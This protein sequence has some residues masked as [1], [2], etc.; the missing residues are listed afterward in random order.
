MISEGIFDVNVKRQEQDPRRFDVTPLTI[1][2][3]SDPEMIRFLHQRGGNLDAGARLHGTPLHQA[4]FYGKLESVRVLLQLGAN[5]N[6]ENE[7]GRTPLQIVKGK[8][9]IETI[10][11][12]RYAAIA[13]LLEDAGGKEKGIRCKNPRPKQ[14]RKVDLREDRSRVERLIRKA[15]RRYVKEH[16]GEPISAVAL[17]ACAILG[18][19]SIC[20]ETGEFN[21]DVPSM[22]HFEFERREFPKWEAAY[23]SEQSVEVVTHTG[24][25]VKVNP[26]GENER[27]QL[28]FYRFLKRVLR[29]LVADGALTRLPRQ[30]DCQV[31]IE[32]VDGTHGGYWRLR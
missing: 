9:P 5:P 16:S 15:V 4:A 22:T 11:R 27:Y 13:C 19:V 6:Y 3:T 29:D 2:A 30:R 14:P 18:S 23:D 20:F 26:Y 1:A 8:Q 12:D 32:F 17:H 24:R 28:P 10:P 25:V 7:K 31:G 21:G